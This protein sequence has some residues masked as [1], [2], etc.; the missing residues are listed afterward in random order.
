MEA[1][2]PRWLATLLLPHALVGAFTLGSVDWLAAFGVLAGLV[3]LLAWTRHR[4]GHPR[5]HVRG[6]A[7]LWLL[8][9]ILA[10]I[11]LRLALD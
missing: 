1:A 5:L 11:L 10:V 8:A 2:S 3:V 4:W 6:A 7:G 9:A